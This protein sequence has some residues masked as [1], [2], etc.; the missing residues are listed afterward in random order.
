MYQNSLS[1]IVSSTCKGEPIM[2][3]HQLSGGYITK[4]FDLQIR[5]YPL[6]TQTDK[7]HLWKV[8]CEDVRDGNVVYRLQS[9]MAD[10]KQMAIDPN[11]P[12]GLG[13]LL[14]DPRPLNEEGQR[15]DAQRWYILPSS[16]G[17]WT[18]V[19]LLRPDL[20]LG[21]MDKQVGINVCYRPVEV[22]GN[23]VPTTSCVQFSPPNPPKDPSSEGQESNA[24]QTRRV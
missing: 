18:I 23:V 4:E 12:T 13:V 10:E 21:P 9:A 8:I 2:I 14:Q 16:N 19:P 11:N 5:T 15:A 3:V 17:C 22:V 24:P 20:V 1:A 6:A 7:K